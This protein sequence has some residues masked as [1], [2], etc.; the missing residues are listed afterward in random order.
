MPPAAAAGLRL[1]PQEA[2]YCAQ[3]TPPGVTRSVRIGRRFPRPCAGTPLP[4]LPQQTRLKI[5][6]VGFG[7]FGQFLAKRMVQAGHEVG[8][9]TW[10][11]LP[12]AAG[13]CHGCNRCRPLHGG[14]SL[15]EGASH[16]VRVKHSPAIPHLTGTTITAG[17]RL[18][19]L[20]RM[21]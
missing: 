19:A 4:P 10:C 8:A 18:R 20:S 14:A 3:C 21:D 2:I 5:G 16:A 17:E 15:R 12:L 7:T 9:A 11:L 6:I 13:Q 1:L